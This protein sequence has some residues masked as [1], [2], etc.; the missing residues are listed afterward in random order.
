MIYGTAGFTAALSIKRLLDEGVD[1][2]KGP[3]LVT[4][5]TGGVGSLAVYMLSRLGFDVTASTGKES[6]TSYLRKLGAQSVIERQTLSEANT[7]PLQ[8][9]H[10]QAAVDPVGGQTLANVLA[11]LAYN[12]TVAVSGLTGGV[13][14]PTTVMPFILRGVNLVGIDS[15]HCPSETRLAIWSFIADKLH[16]P[17]QIK[18][19]K[20]VVP[21]SEVE[22]VLTKITAGTHK[23]R[24]VIKVK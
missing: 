17:E 23:G 1:P 7:R 12:G 4:G 22:H 2:N 18:E 21:L 3:V 6:E 15:V 5:A 14:I 13:S 11:Q 9:S 16:D 10:W 24:T 8:K 19:L 20:S